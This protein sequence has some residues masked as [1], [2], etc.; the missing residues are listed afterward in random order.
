MKKLLTYKLSDVERVLAQNGGISKVL[1]CL[2]CL[3]SGDVKEFALA[4]AL[5]RTPISKP[6]YRKSINRKQKIIVLL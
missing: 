1:H 6:N 2:N 3:F 5:F 4:N